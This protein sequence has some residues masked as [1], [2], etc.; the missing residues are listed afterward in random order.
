MVFDSL[1]KAI[2][3]KKPV[4]HSHNK[5]E[6]LL[7]NFP[8]IYKK[9]AHR[10]NVLLL[11]NSVGDSIMADGFDHE[12]L[13]KIAFLDKEDPSFEKKREKMSQSFDIIITDGSFSSHL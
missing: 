13:L 1:G 6:T 7:S 2:D 8:E 12:A 3:Y 4:I 9:I 10:T 11:G 5:D